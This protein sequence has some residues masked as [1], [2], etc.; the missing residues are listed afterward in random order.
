M[1]GFFKIHM[2]NGWVTLQSC[3]CAAE[4]W[5]HGW[6]SKSSSKHI[7]GKGLSVSFH[8]SSR[9]LL[10][11]ISCMSSCCTILGRGQIK[12]HNLNHVPYLTPP[13]TKKKHK[14]WTG[15]WSEGPAL[16]LHKA[17]LFRSKK[18]KLSENTW[19]VQAL[20][21]LHVDACCI[22]LPI[23]KLSKNHPS[24]SSS[25]PTHQ[26]FCCFWCIVQP[27]PFPKNL[28]NKV[29]KAKR[30]AP[31]F[32]WPHPLSGLIQKTAHPLGTSWASNSVSPVKSMHTST[33]SQACRL[34]TCQ[35]SLMTSSD[36]HNGIQCLT[37][38]ILILRFQQTPKNRTWS[39]CHYA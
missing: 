24:N 6:N 17:H 7:D 25:S 26:C 11:T 36:W 8:Q 15:P 31:N 27:P 4:K 34:Q 14:Y 5:M 39:A 3:Q 1:M 30:S 19:A 16:A 23:Q 18:S 10:R 20:H 33:G 29:P 12:H 2:G 9:M 32:S 38:C 13:G 37:I 28:Y 21:I 35:K 22:R